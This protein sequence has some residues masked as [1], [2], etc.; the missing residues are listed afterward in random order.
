MIDSRRVK[1]GSTEW[2]KPVYWSY[3]GLTLMAAFPCELPFSDASAP[4]PDEVVLGEPKITA[5][6]ISAAYGVP[7]TACRCFTGLG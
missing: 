6:K 5:D 7:F 4:T 3:H 2:P 1:L